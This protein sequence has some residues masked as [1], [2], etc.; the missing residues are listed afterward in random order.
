MKSALQTA[1]HSGKEEKSR[2]SRISTERLRW[3]AGERARGGVG[4]GHHGDVTGYLKSH[5]SLYLDY[6]SAGLV[7]EAGRDKTPALPLRNA[8]EQRPPGFALA[9]PG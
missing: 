3:P 2:G 7:S 1:D 8:T 4:L 6:I 9:S 5:Q